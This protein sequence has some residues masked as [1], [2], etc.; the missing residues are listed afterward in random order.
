MSFYEEMV[1]GGVETTWPPINMTASR[2]ET[3]NQKALAITS[4]MSGAKG[5]VEI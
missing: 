3:T 4:N 5:L 1:G 2:H